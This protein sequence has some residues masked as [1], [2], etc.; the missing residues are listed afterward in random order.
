M[1]RRR[2]QWQQ[3]LSSYGNCKS[4]TKY[5]SSSSSSILKYNKTHFLTFQCLSLQML[6]GQYQ[7]ARERAAQLEKEKQQ[8]SSLSTGQKQVRLNPSSLCVQQQGVL[9]VTKHNN[10]SVAS[11]I[12]Q[13]DFF[14]QDQC[15]GGQIQPTEG[16]QPWSGGFLK[17]KFSLTILAFFFIL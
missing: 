13:A 14:A 16:N 6:F 5:S 17:S 8:R 12:P 10:L 4:N 3:S 2:R 11:R 1:R 9:L 7:E 15:C